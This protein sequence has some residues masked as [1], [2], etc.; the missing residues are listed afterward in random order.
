MRAITKF[1]A[2]GFALAS[3]LVCQPAAFAVGTGWFGG[4]STGVRTVEF[5][6][7]NFSS[8]IDDTL[9]SRKIYGAYQFSRLVGVEMG[10]EMGRLNLRDQGLVEPGS[11][12]PGLRPKGWQFSGVG[13]VSVGQKLGVFGR[14]GAYRGELD[15]SP[16]QASAADGKTKAT[17][18]VGLMY[19]FS[20]NFRV[21]GGWDRYRLGNEDSAATGDVDLLTIGLKYKF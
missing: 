11:L 3:G 17:Y 5:D 12:A 9:R 14:L 16:S 2:F 15:L 21:Q 10:A 13:T 19:D 18:G 6:N 1:S 8:T 20:E 7:R 4:I